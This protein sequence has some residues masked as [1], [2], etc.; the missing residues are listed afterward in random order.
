LITAI[1]RLSDA[2]ISISLPPVLLAVILVLGLVLGV[3]AALI[4]AQ[5]STSLDVLD[6]IN[7]T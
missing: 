6:A 7:A 5:R 1:D 4:P 3:A 2:G